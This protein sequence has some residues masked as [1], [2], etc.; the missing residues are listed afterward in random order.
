MID[1]ETGIDDDFAS[2][3]VGAVRISEKI[4]SYW[5]ERG[6]DSIKVGVVEVAAPKDLKE[7]SRG[8]SCADRRPI[9]SIV[10]NIGPQGF[11][12]G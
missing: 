10:S 6:F 11:P 2:S 12:P 8:Y 7:Y 3:R 9:Y 5:R 1:D 4:L